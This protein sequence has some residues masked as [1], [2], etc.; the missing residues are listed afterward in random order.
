[1]RQR[2]RR[3]SVRVVLIVVSA[4]GAVLLTVDAVWSMQEPKEVAN[5]SKQMKTVCVGRLLIDVPANAQVTLS[6]A[7][8]QGFDIANYGPESNE[9]FAARV[10]SREE[11]INAVKNTAGQKNMVSIQDV[12]HEDVNGRIFVYGF[13]SGYLFE[14]AGKVVYSSVAVDGFAHV[15]GVTFTFRAS[16]YKPEDAGDLERLFKKLKPLGPGIIPTQPGF[17]L[18]GALVLDPLSANDGERIV[19]FAGLPGHED[20]GIALATIAGTT[21]GPG[22]LERNAAHRAGPYA[23]LNAFLSTLLEGKRSINGMDGDEFAFRARELN[24]STGYAFN[25]ETQGTE[26]DVLRPL[27]SLELQTGIS[28]HAGGAPVQSTLSEESLGDLWRRMSSSLRVRPVEQ[29]AQTNDADLQLGLALGT[30]TWAGETCRQTGWW[31]CSQADGHVGV[32]GGTVQLLREGQVVP[33]ALLLPKPGV[34]QKVRGLQPSFEATTPT[35]WRLAD[36]RIHG[37]RTVPAGLAQPGPSAPAPEL[38]GALVEPGHVARSGA[39]CPASG[40][41]RCMD[42]QAMDGARWFAEGAGLP[43]ATYQ[44]S[45]AGMHR[46]LPHPQL[47]TRGSAWKLMR[48]AAVPTPCVSTLT[49]EVVTAAN[50]T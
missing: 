38:E 42:D 48:E 29:P 41:W 34:W 43:P 21:P 11:E 19:M 44:L 7:S 2:L 46:R 30:L 23:F 25:W 33:Q 37:R 3:T 15:N 10:A 9:E 18:D 24:F 14:E 17:C 31:Q 28:P 35:S 4:F 20:L 49:H 22:L 13:N 50:A 8:V 5:M 36:K 12:R 32:Y 6:R 1:M 16:T 39:T 45:G 40:W 26:D 27:V 47:L